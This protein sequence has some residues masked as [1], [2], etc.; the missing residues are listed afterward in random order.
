VSNSLGATISDN[1]TYAFMGL[2]NFG[3][4]KLYAGYEHINF[5]NPNTPLP[6]GFVGIGGYVLVDVNNTAYDNN[7]DLQIFW[8]GVKWAVTPDF[9]LAAG[10]YGYKQNSF[11]TG[12][13]A[14]CTSAVSS[15]CS[16]TEN[17][18]SVLGDYRFNNHFDAYLGT[19][20]SGVTDGLANEFLNTS[21]LTT[22]VGVRVKF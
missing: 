13:N 12:K 14:G 22:T 1:T 5:A 16:G 8:G 17:A 21:T 4:V 15:G 10:Y 3:V 6:T 9:Y 19:L 7:K 11:A 18:F 20:W 2:Y